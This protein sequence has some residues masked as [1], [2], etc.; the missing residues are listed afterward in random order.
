MNPKVSIGM[1]VYNGEKSIREALDSLLAQTFTDFELIISDNASTDGTE[2]I[3]REYVE[4]DPRIRYVRQSE[5]RGPIANFQFVLEEA[6][7]EYFMWA[8]HDDE[9]ESFFVRFCVDNIGNSGSI[10]TAYK[11]RY[12]KSGLVVNC[13]LPELSGEKNSPDDTVK[14]LKTSQSVMIYGL[15]K[16]SN[17]LF[18]LDQDPFDWF[19]CYFCLKIIHDYGFKTFNNVQLY[20]YGIDTEKYVAKPLNRRFCNPFYYYFKS[21]KYIVYSR[22]SDVR[23][24]LLHT[25]SLFSFLY[26]RTIRE[27]FPSVKIHGASKV[28]KRASL[29]GIIRQVQT[30]RR[31]V[32]WTAQDQSMLEF[33]SQFVSR[34]ELCFDVGAN[35]GNRVK[36]F[37]KLGANVI[38]VEPQPE[39]VAIMRTAFGN[40]RQ[41]KVVQKAL[42]ES[43]GEA[44]IMISNANTIS[45]LSSEWIQ[46]VRLSGRFFEYSWNKK[47]IVPLT[48]LDRLIEQHGIPAF[49]KVDVEGFEFQVIKGLTQPVKLLSFE[50]IP[51]FIEATFECIDHLQRLGDI[52]LNYSV[53]ESL[54]LALEQ[55]VPPQ[56]MVE[57]LR[58]FRDDNR[59][60]GD[61][62]V[63]FKV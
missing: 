3:C 5:N 59:L 50:F 7:G 31:L 37:L 62:Y 15:H 36:I 18:F 32:Q 27:L 51:E 38:A 61:V 49:I 56:E 53:G 11:I 55:W 22:K 35:I 9:R 40:N 26:Y 60:F 46:A 57:I 13:A 58:G 12:R 4:R 28:I 29:Y 33:Y 23:A 34:S 20:C 10:M 42:G 14:Y 1:P 16:R 8:A 25:R 39:C 17:I 21:F 44:E 43:E 48:T 52:R 45:S 2:A 6:V 24:I 19:D 63:R 54:Q 47:E 41:F 30:K